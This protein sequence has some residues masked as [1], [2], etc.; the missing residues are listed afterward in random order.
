MS[1]AIESLLIGSI[2][3]PSV[4]IRTAAIYVH[5]YSGEGLMESFFPNEFVILILCC[6]QDSVAGLL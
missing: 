6:I 3:R 1:S 4:R 2:V 5:S